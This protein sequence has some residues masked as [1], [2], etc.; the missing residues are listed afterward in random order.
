MRT[1]K[2]DCNV[3]TRRQYSILSLETDFRVI[4]RKLY[5]Y[6]DRFYSS[7]TKGS[8]FRHTVQLKTLFCLFPGCNSYFLNAWIITYE[9]SCFFEYFALVVEGMICLL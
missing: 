1:N 6:Q 8:L 5:F 4:F 7:K 3:T 2:T 9:K